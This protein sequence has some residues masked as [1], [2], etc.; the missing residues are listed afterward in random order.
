MFA[1]LIWHSWLELFRPTL[2][3]FGE[4]ELAFLSLYTGS[5]LIEETDNK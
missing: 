2:N 1:Q 3:S 5:I 4:I